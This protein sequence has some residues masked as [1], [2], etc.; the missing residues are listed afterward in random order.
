MTRVF[1][2]QPDEY[3]GR[4]D[5]KCMCLALLLTNATLYL[6]TYI[7]AITDSVTALLC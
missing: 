4:F 2:A 6:L 3:S 7:A 5:T 1:H